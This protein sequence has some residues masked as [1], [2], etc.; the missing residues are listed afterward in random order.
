ME[1]TE[2]EFDINEYLK[3]NRLKDTSAQMS[4]AIRCKDGFLMSVQ[5]SYA[6]YCS[7]RENGAYPY[8]E[9]EIGFPSELEELL[10]EY[11]ECSEQPP[12]KKV[13]AYVPLDVVMKVIEKHGGFDRAARPEDYK[14]NNEEEVEQEHE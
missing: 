2:K 10:M 12:T 3:G 5:V 9:L 6:H 14:S 13:Y 1:K 7:P 11:A 8:S 4:Q